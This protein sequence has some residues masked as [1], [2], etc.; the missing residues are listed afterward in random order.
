MSQS[1]NGSLDSNGPA[2]G[3]LHVEDDSRTVP[4]ETSNSEDFGVALNGKTLDFMLQNKENYDQVLKKVL[5]K[6]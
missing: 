3:V 1:D 5:Y 2:S 6:A 4:W